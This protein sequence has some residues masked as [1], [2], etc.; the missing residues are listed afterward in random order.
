M[1]PQPLFLMK[2]S[3]NN[4]HGSLWSTTVFDGRSFSADSEAVYIRW[5]IPTEGGGYR[6]DVQVIERFPST[7]KGWH[8]LFDGIVELMNI[9][10]AVRDDYECGRCFM[11][12]IGYT[13][14]DELGTFGS[15][16]E[17]ESHWKAES[18]DVVD[19]CL[20]VMGILGE[21]LMG[22]LYPENHPATEWSIDDLLKG[23]EPKK[24]RN[25]EPI[26]ILD[27]A[28]EGELSYFVANPID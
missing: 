16:E 17:Y 24:F 18:L 6:P 15:W 26:N 8:A 22:F 14:D 21:D 27:H 13:D 19:E 3:W 1:P 23:W 10:D 12:D 11:Y 25:W 9:E 2:N 4:P 20:R 5:M 7:L 28:T